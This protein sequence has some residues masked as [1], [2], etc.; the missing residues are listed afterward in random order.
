MGKTKNASLER[1]RVVA[2]FEVSNPGG[3]IVAYVLLGAAPG[4]TS[5]VLWPRERARPAKPL[6]LHLRVLRVIHLRFA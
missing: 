4:P 3:S 5:S 6:S 2:S 1:M